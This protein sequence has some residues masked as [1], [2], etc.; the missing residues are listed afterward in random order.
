MD[1]LNLNIT[2]ILPHE[3]SFFRCD[4][5]KR[6]FVVVTQE[7][8]PLTFWRDLKYA[9]TDQISGFRGARVTLHILTNGVSIKT[10]FKLEQLR[11]AI[12]M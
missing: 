3:L 10:F 7:S 5:F 9:E 1:C 4:H 2:Y 11:L 12:D 6:Q 8:H